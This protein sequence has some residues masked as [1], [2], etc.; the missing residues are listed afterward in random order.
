[1]VGHD[2]RRYSEHTKNAL[3]IGLMAAG[4]DVHDAGAYRV[5]GE[6][7][8]LEPGMCFTVEPGIYVPADDEDADPR[9]R[10]IGVRIEDDLAVTE[11]SHENLTEAI[12]KAIDDVEAW[13]RAG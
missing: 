5:E 10:G 3:T 1:M 11:D 7:R 2:F 8:P 13:M 6:P 12:P 9:F 4:L